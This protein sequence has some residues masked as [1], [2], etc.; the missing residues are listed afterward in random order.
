MSRIPPP[1]PVTPADRLARMRETL[2]LGT[3]GALRAAGFAWTRYD[4]D[5]A[6]ASHADCAGCAARISDGDWGDNH[7]RAF[8]DGALWL[9]PYC[10]AFLQGVES[11][12]EG[13]P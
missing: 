13:A 9:C 4:A 3:P 5:D 11:G 2:A 7:P 10:H 1:P 12:R 6:G 8:R